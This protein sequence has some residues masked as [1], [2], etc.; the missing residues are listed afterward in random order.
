MAP[1]MEP[2]TAMRCSVRSRRENLRIDITTPSRARGGTMMLTR[3]PSARRASTMGL[4]SSTR[5][6]MLAAMR[7]ATFSTWA[8]SRNLSGVS[9]RMP[10][11]ST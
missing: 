1:D 3:L 5:R 11:R 7:W 9:S 2:P 6:P 8:L 4:D 10:L